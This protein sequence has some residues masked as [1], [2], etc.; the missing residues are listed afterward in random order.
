MKIVNDQSM[1]DISLD[2][3]KENLA[4]ESTSFFAS[5]KS[6]I[7]HRIF[8]RS[9]PAKETQDNDESDVDISET[10]KIEK[11]SS[12]DEKEYYNEPSS[13]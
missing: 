11:K 1:Q 5:I 8:G 7:S 13:I 12:E 6:V 4:V 10:V 2:E 9:E 3:S